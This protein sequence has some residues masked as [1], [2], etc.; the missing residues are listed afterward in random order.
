MNQK[1][2]FLFVFGKSRSCIDF[3]LRKS[4]V[5]YRL[6]AAAPFAAAAAVP[7]ERRNKCPQHLAPIRL[8][9]PHCHRFLR[10]EESGFC[11]WIGESGA[12]RWTFIEE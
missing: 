5:S 11:S 4:R 10:G 2:I 8:R 7:F 1:I 12:G 3:T 6:S 9:P